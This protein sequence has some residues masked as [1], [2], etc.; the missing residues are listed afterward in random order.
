[1]SDETDDSVLTR[2]DVAYLAR[3]ARIEL[4]E[5]ELDELLPQLVGILDAVAVVSSVADADIP[6]TSHA[7]PLS[8]VFRPDEVRP[9]LTPEQALAA[10]PAAERQR[11]SV[12]RIL[13]EEP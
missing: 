1:M 13:D 2:G 3:L 5:A 6:P 11:F 12:P 7:V 4:T 10:A 8:N 9:G